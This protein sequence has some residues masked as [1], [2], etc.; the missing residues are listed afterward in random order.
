[1]DLNEYVVNEYSPKS[2]KVETLSKVQSKSRKY[3]CQKLARKTLTIS[4]RD[5]QTIVI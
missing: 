1:M 3:M 5:S 2:E 4:T